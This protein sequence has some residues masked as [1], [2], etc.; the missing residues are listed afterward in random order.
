M[1]MTMTTATLAAY[2][3]QFHYFPEDDEEDI[4]FDCITTVVPSPVVVEEEDSSSE[5][6]D[7]SFD[8]A[9][10]MSPSME[11]RRTLETPQA[12]DMMTVEQERIIHVDGEEKPFDEVSFEFVDPSSSIV[13][14]A[15][16]APA[17]VVS[18][19]SVKSKKSVSFQIP[20]KAYRRTHDFCHPEEKDLNGTP[21]TSYITTSS[22]EEEDVSFLSSDSTLEYP[23]SEGEDGEE[24]VFHLEDISGEASNMEEEPGMDEWCL[25]M[26]FESLGSENTMEMADWVTKGYKTS[27]RKVK[28]IVLD[29]MVPPPEEYAAEEEEENSTEGSDDVSTKSAEQAEEKDSIP[30]EEDN[31]FPAPLIVSPPPPR[32]ENNQG[33]TFYTTEEEFNNDDELEASMAKSQVQEEERDLVTEHCVQEMKT[34]SSVSNEHETAEDGDNVL[35]S[36]INGLVAAEENKENMEENPNLFELF[37]ESTTSEDKQ[38][39][40]PE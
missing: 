24:Q 39:G 4:P 32:G 10:E 40:Q 23:S 17:A 37:Q 36:R 15:P 20:V 2:S 38:N 13:I 27:K 11:E 3:N 22:E 7:P 14:D 29:C 8:C 5:E 19:S 21:D 30:K 34:S 33:V 6:E 18:P 26:V 31:T 25:N 12:A 35:C 1:T 16:A 28:G 9:V